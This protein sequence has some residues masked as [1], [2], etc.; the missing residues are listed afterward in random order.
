MNRFVSCK[1]HP[2]EVKIGLITIDSNNHYP[3]KYFNF[4]RGPVS[5]IKTFALTSPKKMPIKIPLRLPHG[6]F[7]LYIQCFSRS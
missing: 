1:I 4:A 7:S 2:K 5:V 3:K 6:K